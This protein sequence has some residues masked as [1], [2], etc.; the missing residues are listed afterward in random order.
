M[1][2][3]YTTLKLL[4]LPPGIILVLMLGAFFLVRGTLGRTLLLVAWSVLL[5]MSIP[6]FSESLLAS[7]QVY[8]AIPPRQLDATGAD[9]IVVL[10]AGVYG[11]AGEYGES[12]VDAV[13]FERLRY[14]A[15]LHRK[16]GLPIFVTGGGA[17]QASAV[18]MKKSLRDELGVPT[19][20][21][22]DLSS[23]TWENAALI[24]PMLRAAGIRRP[25]LV[26]HAW[27]M[28]RG[29]L[30]FEHLGFDVVPAPTGFVR[31]PGDESASV[32]RRFSDWLPQASA[33]IISY[34]A[35]HELIGSIFYDF[36][37]FMTEPVPTPE[38]LAVDGIPSD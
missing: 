10:A 22:E 25:L 3:L 20:G 9:A 2:I 38:E 34:Y 13:T 27:H 19:E 37:V 12:V 7:R 31:A 28:P 30:V 11:D 29:V 6:A 17:P 24:A 23:S 1:S 8:D 35:I 18:L 33:F 16:T 26:T 4:L 14:A 15:F 5:I 21:V 32:Q 36:R